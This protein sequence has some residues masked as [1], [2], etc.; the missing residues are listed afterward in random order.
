[1]INKYAKIEDGI[2]VNTIVCEDSEITSQNGLHI[3]V[4]S[5][6][7]PASIGYE[8]DSVKNKFKS[9]QQYP[10]WVLNEDTLLWESPVEKPADAEISQ[11]GTLIG[12]RWNEESQQWD[13]V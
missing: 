13:K 12:Y 1:M 3:K 7:N 8:Y 2:V 6:T 10:S 9:H 4:D 5:T 11:Y